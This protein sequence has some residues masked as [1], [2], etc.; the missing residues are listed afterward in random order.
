MTSSLPTRQPPRAMQ[1]DDLDAVIELQKV[2]Y[3]AEF[4]EPKSSFASKL[5]AAPDS[6]WVAAGPDRLLAYLVCLPI[7]GDALPALHAPDWCKPHQPD[8]LYLHDLAIHPDA[9]GTGLARAMLHQA[10]TAAHSQGLSTM[11]LIAVQGSVPFWSRHGFAPATAPVAQLMAKKL[12]SF[13]EDA[14]FMLRQ[15]IAS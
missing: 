2:C 11:G 6:C 13:G 15:G 9:R 8:W 7:E 1:E 5:R 4:H 14:V 10:T 12:D 3:S